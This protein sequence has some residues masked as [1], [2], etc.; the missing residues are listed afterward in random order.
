MVIGLAPSDDLEKTYREIVKTYSH[1]QHK[2]LTRHPKDDLF[3]GFIEDVMSHTY[4]VK[5]LQSIDKQIDFLIFCPTS[6]SDQKSITNSTIDAVCALHGIVGNI[7]VLTG[8]TSA[9]RTSIYEDTCDFSGIRSITLRS[10]HTHYDDF[11]IKR[12]HMKHL[13][14]TIVNEQDYVY[15]IEKYDRACKTLFFF[16]KSNG[17]DFF[18][19]PTDSKTNVRGITIGSMMDFLSVNT[20]L[21]LKCWHASKD[22]HAEFSKFITN[23]QHIFIASESDLC[24]HLQ[25]RRI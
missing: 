15:F 8:L 24:K 21:R 12:E 10:A 7:I 1:D 22:G 16:L 2:R 19:I 23:N 4:G 11:V 25:M 18:M 9:F 5:Y 20:D 3:N 14:D 6:G 13:I 17:I